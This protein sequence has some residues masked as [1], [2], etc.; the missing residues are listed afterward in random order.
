[1]RLRPVLS[2]GLA[3]SWLAFAGC[4]G[5]TT[6]T[7]PAKVEDM[8]DAEK[9]AFKADLLK[10]SDEEAAQQAREAPKDAPKGKSADDEERAA[11]RK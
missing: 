5:S 7:V 11:Q 9:A 6:K 10:V 2:T 1:M 8:T 4:G 3:L